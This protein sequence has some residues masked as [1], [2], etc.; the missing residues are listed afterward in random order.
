MSAP[1]RVCIVTG[2]GINTDREMATAFELAG[3]KPLRLHVND[4][5][6]APA[7]LSRFA[8][9]VVPG[10]FSFGD[11][12]GSGALLAAL[13]ARALRD[14]LARFVER[15]GLV[16]GVCN[17]FQVLVRM[18][19]VPDTGG[20]AAAGAADGTAQSV[21]LVHNDSGRFEDR[22]V[23]LAFDPA[24]PCVWTRGIASLELPVRHGEGKLVAPEAE[25]SAIDAAHLGAARYAPPAAD[26]GEA[27][28]SPLP[29]PANPN[30]SLRNL[31]GLCDPTGHV[32][33]LMP[34]PE[35]F[36]HRYHHP[37]WRN[38][39]PTANATLDQA[40][41]GLFRNAVHHAAARE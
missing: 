11:H 13:L 24:S 9:F 15:G 41:L 38:T 33:G 27:G 29:Y 32:F 7:A 14:P 6:A 16:L 21:A 2:F 39:P 20:A 1:V 3:A 25:L 37:T 22:W 10:G 28:A 17:G 5:I 34:H 12:V 35:A 40:A 36:L 8:I 31:A 4:L 26:P 18:G 23:R 30:G 19:L